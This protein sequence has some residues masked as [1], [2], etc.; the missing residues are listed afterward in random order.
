MDTQKSSAFEQAVG[1]EVRAIAS[2]KSLT[3]KEIQ[4]RSGVGQKSFRRY[5]VECSRPIPLEALMSVAAAMGVSVADLIRAA[6]LSLDAGADEPAPI[7]SVAA[8]PPPVPEFR[9]SRG[10]RLRPTEHSSQR[11]R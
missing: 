5:F 6:E 2:R 7:V 9:T 3:H 4:E 8:P 11:P 1:A 10:V